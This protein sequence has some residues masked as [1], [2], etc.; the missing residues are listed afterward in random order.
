MTS[1]FRPRAALV[2]LAAFLAVPP[3]TYRLGRWWGTPDAEPSMRGAKTL[4]PGAS[5]AS[6]HPTR[7]KSGF[8][9]EL[10]AAQRLDGLSSAEA[11]SQ[12]R[13]GRVPRHRLADSI[14]RW[15]AEDPAAA[16]AWAVDR[17]SDDPEPI[18]V[19]LTAF[20]K[21][22][23]EAALEAC[24]KRDL[25]GDP[26]VQSALWQ[27]VVAE[28]RALAAK[29][30]RI[31]VRS[32]Y[33]D[34]FS[35]PVEM[36]MG[37]LFDIGERIAALPSGRTRTSLLGDLARIWPPDSPV[38]AWDWAK[39]LPEQDRRAFEGKSV[40]ALEQG[41]RS[42][43]TPERIARALEWLS[44]PEHGRER[45]EYG[46][47]IVSMRARSDLNGAWGWAQDHLS[48]STL[49]RAAEDLA[50]EVSRADVDQARNFVEALPMGMPRGRAAASVA[51]R[52]VETGDPS[53]VARWASE[54]KVPEGDDAWCQL[55]TPWAEKNPAQLMAGLRSQPDLLPPRGLR[56]AVAKL[57]ETD[58]E[59]TLTWA[60]SVSEA[61]GGAAYGLALNAL[62]G[63][64]PGRAA[65]L[66]QQDSRL[67]TDGEIVNEIVDTFRQKDPTAAKAWADRLPAGSLKDRAIDVLHGRPN[68]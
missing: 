45:S 47:A 11:G 7:E 40:L 19:A 29:I 57:M 64:D 33:V 27:L 6:R 58:P 44:S 3:G 9:A 14:S 54:Q 39:K 20:L 23:P 18:E 48:G 53:V 66:L 41:N 21:R 63:D 28:D 2:W 43:Q 68:E 15:A 5:T 1:L 55:G 42:A 51:Q 56:P 16:F 36:A 67:V 65:A 59:G 52:W 22:D 46:P 24:R 4:P 38:D 50:F 26:S 12:V 30:A 62:S 37:D 49:T 10:H 8:L 31:L 13:S 34:P 17:C 60:R 35:N 32:N 25:F 61:T